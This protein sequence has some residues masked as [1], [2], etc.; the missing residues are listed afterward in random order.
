MKKIRVYLPLGTIWKLN[1]LSAV[2]IVLHIQ[3]C[4]Q[5]EI[6]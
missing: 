3:V 5:K 1:L 4:K 6:I 2:Y